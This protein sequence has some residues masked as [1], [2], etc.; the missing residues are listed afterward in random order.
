MGARKVSKFDSNPPQSPS[1]PGWPSWK[2]RLISAL[3]VLHLIALLVGAAAAAPSSALE[4]VL[5]SAFGRYYDLVDQGYAYRYYAPEPPPTPVVTA[6]VRFADG[7]PEV[8]VRLPRR[9]LRPR[10]RYQRQLALAFHLV[11]DFDEARRGTGDGRRS[12]WAR[13]YARHL[14]RAW[15][16]SST[17]TLSA[18]M[19]LI[20]DPR[21]VL[22]P[23]SAAGAARVDLDAEEFYTAPERI[24]EF[25]C[26]A[27]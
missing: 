5:S 9:G 1:L 12:R 17:V 20:P 10:L 14:A 16:G 22:E 18:L 7:R 26:D 19:H 24:G 21:R 15:P 25:S 27:L 4:R 2:R 8:I 23:A 3:L 11:A 13:S 6:T